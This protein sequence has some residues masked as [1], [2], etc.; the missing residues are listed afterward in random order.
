VDATEI[1]AVVTA[2]AKNKTHRK[3]QN[4]A[5]FSAKTHKNS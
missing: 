2:M 4:N 5:L 3:K 1:A